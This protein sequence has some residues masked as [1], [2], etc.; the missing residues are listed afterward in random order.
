MA[1]EANQ[2]ATSGETWTEEYRNESIYFM[3]A[4]ENRHPAAAKAAITEMRRLIKE[5]KAFKEEK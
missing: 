4:V 1:R 3:N 2:D 5:N